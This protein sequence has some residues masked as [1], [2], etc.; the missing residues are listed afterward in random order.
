M[1]KAETKSNNSL[2]PSNLRHEERT[3]S[4][5]GDTRIIKQSSTMVEFDDIDYEDVQNEDDDEQQKE[6]FKAIVYA[7]HEVG[8][9]EEE[10][11][12]EIRKINKT[13]SVSDYEIIDNPRENDELA[14][15]QALQGDQKEKED[16]QISVPVEE[17]QINEIKQQPEEVIIE[18]KID[19][20]QL[21]NELTQLLSLSESL[22]E[23]GNK[24]F[25]ESS[26]KT[27]E[28]L[29]RAQEKYLKASEV[30]LARGVDF[31][32]EQS[33]NK[34]YFT[35]VK[36]AL[37]NA[38]MM[39]LKLKEY[40]LAF[41]QLKYAK[42]FLQDGEDQSKIQFRLAACLNGLER[43][44]DALDI[45]KSMIPTKD[46]LVKLEYNKALGKSSFYSN[47]KNIEGVKEENRVTQSQ[48]D[49]YERMFNPQKRKEEKKKRQE[50]KEQKEK[51]EAPSPIVKYGIPAALL[52][53]GLALFLYKKY[54]K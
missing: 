9:N 41:D 5:A 6:G 36:L 24:I 33:L 28:Q 42:Q 35:S 16:I 39:N 44:K 23:E 18:N 17:V 8:L 22:K 43:Y 2:V 45:L 50:D 32:K 26:I 47:P 46:A 48:K 51:D 11:K 29:K 37:M 54:K 38:A 13:I 12:D 4:D 34:K 53:G 3:R 49:A 19:N 7:E 27:N 1:D 31:V 10:E 15:P 25:N 14:T 20:S 52:V 40:Q 21:I 30:L